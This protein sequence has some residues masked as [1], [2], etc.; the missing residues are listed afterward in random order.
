MKFF[1]IIL[2]PLGFIIF[3]ISA[4]VLFEPSSDP[5]G[6][7]VYTPSLAVINYENNQPLNS[8][9]KIEFMTTGT[10]DLIITSLTGDMKVVGLK[11]GNTVLNPVSEGNS[12][13]YEGYQC[14]ENSFLLVQIL[15]EKLD[16]ELR[17]GKEIQQVQNIAPASASSSSKSCGC[18]K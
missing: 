17:F 4:L 7:F 12:A 14:K 15:S 18:G 3:F 9:L 6:F 16:I 5:T 10:N 1:K 13:F 8:N 2:I 11:C